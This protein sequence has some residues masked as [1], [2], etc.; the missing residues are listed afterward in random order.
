MSGIVKM[1]DFIL[2]DRN[3]LPW[4]LETLRVAFADNIK[5]YKFVHVCFCEC[6]CACVFVCVLYIGFVVQII[7]N[8]T[9]PSFKS[10]KIC[11]ENNVKC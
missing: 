9:E 5:Q 2:Q 11:R 1:Y 7:Y 3:N 6:V 4:E 8:I 10:V